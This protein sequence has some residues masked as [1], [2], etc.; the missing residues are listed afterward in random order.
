MR[1]PSQVP[2]EFVGLARQFRREADREEAANTAALTPII[3]PINRRLRR[4]PKRQLRDG[5]FR[6]LADAWESLPRDYRLA[7][8]ANTDPRGRRGLILDVRVHAITMLS[9]QWEPDATEPSI[10]LT[11]HCLEVPLVRKPAAQTIASISLHALARRYERGGD[12]SH[13]LILD[14]LRSIVRANVNDEEAH[15]TDQPFRIQTP[16]GIWVG[17]TT[18]VELSNGKPTVQFVVR[19]FLPLD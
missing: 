12:R 19:T 5:D 16:R 2:V 14:D 9:D 15:P 1:L 18:G 6:R 17:T 3:G 4:Y 7:F 8:R 11:T 10:A 13:H